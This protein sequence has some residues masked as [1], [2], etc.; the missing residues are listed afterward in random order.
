M[1]SSV[2]TWAQLEE[3]AASAPAPRDAARDDEATSQATLRLFDADSA[4][5][6]RVTLYRDHHFWCPYCQKVVLWLEER[7]VPYRVRKVTMRCY[8]AKEKWY[9]QIV[10]SG[11]LPALELDGE[12]ITESDDILAALERAFGA[13]R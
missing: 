10:P 5:D 3:A 1:S 13:L 12:L 7:R 9:T 8:G 6:V 11:M 2:M 4:R